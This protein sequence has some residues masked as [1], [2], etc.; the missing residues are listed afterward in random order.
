ML[1]KKKQYLRLNNNYSS[2]IFNF[3]GSTTGC[4][5]ND[6]ND[7]QRKENYKCDI[8]YATNNELGFD[9]LRD[10]MK[11]DI[12]DM[13]Q[14]DHNFCIVDEVDSILIDESRT[15]LIISGKVEDKS[16]L[17]QTANEFVKRLEKKDYDLDEKNKNAILNDAGVDKIEKL[18]VQKNLL[19]NNNFYDPKNL[20][21]V[22][23]VNQALK[24]NHLFK[25]GKDYIVKDEEIVIIDEQT[26][27]Q[28]PGRRFSDGLHQS[29]EAKEN[30]EIQ[31]ENQ[32]LASTTYQNYFKL[33]S[34]LAGC[35]G[36]AS[37]ESQ[38]FYEIYN[39][40]VVEI[41]TNKKMIR[42][43]FND[44]IFRTAKEKDEA[45]L[46]KIYEL[47]LKGQPIL[48]FTFLTGF[49]LKLSNSLLI[50]FLFGTVTKLLSKVLILVLLNPT[51]S[52]TPVIP[53]IVMISPTVK[54]LSKNIVKEPSRF[55]RLSFDANATATPPIPRPAANA[56]ISIPKI[57]PRI[58]KRPK[59]TTKT[60]PISIAKGTN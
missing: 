52:T 40:S 60:F 22:H 41:P 10:N 36:T 21:L 4:I 2:K 3:L 31:S 14:R 33:Y 35:T 49:K 9:Y 55:S 15:P 17:Y 6:L 16:N 32:T 11:Y 28:L 50:K 39:L 25:A 56:V 38:E 45:I 34:K 24:A 23:L 18:A 1:K 5:T 19:K 57:L 43:D 47:N 58:I 27:R 46:K 59:I 37:T 8:S 26:G 20:T 48:V 13:V 7:V 54:G 12:N 53:P 29:L 30:V 51:F 42:N 44:Q